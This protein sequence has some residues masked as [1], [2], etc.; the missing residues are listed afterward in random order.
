VQINLGDGVWH[1]IESQPS[2]P[3]S[4]Y[5]VSYDATSVTLDPGTYT[6]QARVIDTAGNTTAPESQEVVIDTSKPPALT[7]ALTHDTGVSNSD[8]ITNDGTLTLSGFEDGGGYG[9]NYFVD[10]ALTALTMGAISVQGDTVQIDVAHTD[11]DVT[12]Q[13]WQVDVAGNGNQSP[14]TSISFT[15]D[16][17]VAAPTVALLNDTGVSNSDKITSDGTLNV[18]GL[19]TGA[20][21]EYSTDGGAHWS[22]TFTPAEG[23]NDVLVRQTDVAGNVSAAT[24]FSF[25]LESQPETSATILT[26]GD[27]QSGGFTPIPN[28][29]GTTDTGFQI[30]GELS[31]PLGAD[32]HVV[33][34]RNG[35]PIGTALVSGA[36]WAYTDAV[37]AY[38]DY[39]YTAFVENSAGSS[40][41]VSD[42]YQI[43]VNEGFH[44]GS[45]IRGWLGS[46]LD[47]TV[48]V[49]D[50]KTA[51]ESPQD[52]NGV[53]GW[54]RS[55]DFALV[56]AG[57]NDTYNL[58]PGH[59]FVQDHAILRY[60]LIDPN[61][62]TGGNGS[63][64]VNGFVVGDFIANANADQIDLTD[65]LSSTTGNHSD[66]VSVTTSGANTLVSVDLKGDGSFA[67]VLTIN[68]VHTTLAELTANQ[69]I[70]M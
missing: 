67:T 17:Q 21:V 37:P 2:T 62:P 4:P 29:T 58:L 68:D 27:Y 53:I 69:Q 16:T 60:D 30:V 20:T 25:T 63:D 14:V 9:Y 24:D 64:V 45:V 35:E 15:L 49:E 13:V 7:V 44:A 46:D 65:L 31:A 3:G 28:G 55:S 59:A 43:S 41:P 6:F 57:G 61:D 54:P 23:D 47:D 38:G 33:V 10:G 34:L 1:D 42:N 50:I 56:G 8:G 52:G 5:F 32:E 39:T 48:T 26:L 40:G 19:E 70:V 36:D 51:I 12:V 22:A 11:G 66:H 18:T